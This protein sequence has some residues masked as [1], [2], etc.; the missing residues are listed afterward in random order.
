MATLAQTRRRPR[1]R[2]LHW[3]EN[4]DGWLFIAPWVVGFLGFT[5]GPMIASAVMA[6]MDWDILTPPKLSGMANFARMA[7]DPLFTKSLYNTA[8]YTFLGV[9]LYLVLSLLAAVL[10]NTGLRGMNVY[11][12]FFFLPSLTPAVA[13]ALLWIWIFNPDFGL[14]N[15][16]LYQLGLPP[17]K[18]LFDVNLAKPSFIIM[19]VW[20]IGSQMIIFLAGLQGIPDQLYEAASIDGANA[21]RRFV[22]VTLPMLSP[23]VFFNLVIGI[24]GSFQVFTTA[25]IATGGGP[26]NATL[27]YVLYLYR[28]AFDYFKMGYASS[29][30]WVLFLIVLF[31]TLIQFWG[32]RAWVYYEVEEAR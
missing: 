32:A 27:F 25:Y 1:Y 31:F 26:Q 7:Q 3:R 28:N 2:G 8:F 13:N 18:W 22:S 6:F 21:W 12:T 9:P 15:A 4:V 20:H 14:A 16:L 5:L 29:L 30:A 23:T 19:G 24:I 10:L 11:R 17:Q